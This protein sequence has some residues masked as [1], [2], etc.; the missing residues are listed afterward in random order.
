MKKIVVGITGASGMALSIRLMEMLAGTPG[1]DVGCIVS[2]G[3]R[4][5]LHRESDQDET[6]FWALSRQAWRPEDMDA[7]PAGG[8]WWRP[9]NDC[10]MIICP[11]SMGTLGALASGISMNLIHRSADVALKEKIRLV[12]VTRES[13]LSLIHLKNMTLLAQAGATIMPFSPGLYFQPASI[14]ELLT[15]FCWRVFDQIGLQHNGPIWSDEKK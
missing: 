12:L 1:V 2:A 7:A 11:C 8:S 6:F 10:A 13:P 14:N 15:Q 4:R 5:V 3:A 9:S